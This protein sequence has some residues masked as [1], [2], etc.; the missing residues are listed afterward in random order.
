MSQLYGII[1]KRERSKQ[2]IEKKTEYIYIICICL[3]LRIPQGLKL[4]MEEK[5]LIDSI[6]VNK[7][8]LRYL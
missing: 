5:R 3:L 6:K 4:Q 7:I 2:L 8:N 1:I